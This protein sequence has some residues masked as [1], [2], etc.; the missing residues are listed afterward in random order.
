MVG[1][2]FALESLE[3]RRKV[4]EQVG[5]RMRTLGADAN[6]RPYRLVADTPRERL[7]RFARDMRPNSSADLF[8][9]FVRPLDQGAHLT[10]VIDG[11]ARMESVLERISVTFRRT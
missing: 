6:K 2:G 8:N 10:T 4:A 1:R 5:V 11:L 7:Q 3:Q 9:Q